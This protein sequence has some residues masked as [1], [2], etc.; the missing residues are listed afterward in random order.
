MSSTRKKIAVFLSGLDEEYQ[1]QITQGIHQF[2]AAH[3]IDVLHFIAFGGILNNG[4][5]DTGEYNIFRLP[6]LKALD[7]VILLTNTIARP[8]T[9]QEIVSQVRASGIPAV[10]VDADYGDFYSIGVDNR[11]AMA[12]I[13][14]HFTDTHG[15]RRINYI[16]GPDDNPDSIER[17]AG[18][19]QVLTEHNIPI[20][21]DRIYH[22]S[23]QRRDGRT[24]VDVFLRSELPMP[25]AIVCAND[26]MAVSVISALNAHGLRVPEDIMVSGFDNTYNARN[27]APEIT[28]VA[29]PLIQCGTLACELLY[30]AWNGVQQERVHKLEMQPRFSESCG[31]DAHYCDTIRDFKK[32]NYQIQE[33]FS[34]DISLL[35]RMAC[36][37][38]EC[39]NYDEFIEALKEFVLETNC[40]EFYLCLCENW[41]GHKLRA[42]QAEPD[43]DT[44]DECLVEGYTQRMLVPLSYYDGKFRCHEDFLVD[45]M[46]PAL[47]RQVDHLRCFYFVPLHF[48][49]H[50][51]GYYAICNTAF[52]MRSSLF[53]SWSLNL[54]NSM[55]NIRRIIYLDNAVQELDKLYSTD[56]LSGIAN[57]N[58]FRRQTEPIF[59]RCIAEQKP[60][61]VMFI[62]MDGLKMINDTYGH[63]SGDIAIRSLAAILQ[64]CC[65]N[66]EICCRFGGDE[67]IIFAAGYTKRDADRLTGN[68]QK[69]MMEFNLLTSM[70]FALHASSGYHIAVPT[71]DK[72]LFAMVTL[73]D[74]IMYTEKRKKRHS[75]YLKRDLSGRPEDESKNK[76][77]EQE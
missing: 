54:S 20:E 19:K 74:T 36:S 60:V 25:E 38:V 77:N 5:Y 43:A 15:L 66:G 58:G 28:S 61:M 73:A 75:K 39:A 68:L 41:L 40:E 53:H 33:D 24:A 9:V 3:G 6:N 70:P 4:S 27:Y 37:L 56:P 17:L 76:T 10:S 1:N 48:R 45:E 57:R 16:S 12:Q 2:A 71:P 62:D 14:R 52:P 35:S 72:S 8:E 26:T 44:A 69:K 51:L 55:E 50:C 64:E 34:I 46:L 22:G 65:T 30:N 11:S 49:E 23:F 21:E 29:R 59:D 18:Y 7:G 47:Y 67:F 32:H 31:C 13:V 63:K 42:N